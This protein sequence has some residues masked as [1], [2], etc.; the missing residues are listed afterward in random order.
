MH[1][2]D[3]KAPGLW[4]VL[5]LPVLAQLFVECLFYGAGAVPP[6]AQSLG[7]AVCTMVIAYLMWPMLWRNA[8]LHPRNL[9][10][11]SLV[12]AAIAALLMMAGTPVGTWLSLALP[13]AAGVLIVCVLLGALTLFLN[14][15]VKLPASIAH[16]VVLSTLLLTGTA[17][18]WL[19][20]LA[21][22]L[23]SQ[24]FTDLV[25]ALSP[26]G[27][28]TSLIDYDA[29]RSAWFYTHTP[30]GGLRY[31][32]PNPVFFTM[33]YCGLAVLML[34]IST[35]FWRHVAVKKDDTRFTSFHPIY[36]EPTP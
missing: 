33:L 18:L 34:S 30:L 24:V 25:I 1:I 10:V 2:N 36:K 23:A 19:S 7:I 22:V 16:R 14:R 29:L 17:P 3:Y 28:L 11:W 35:V 21:G 4:F 13:L 32:Y 26:V 31:D 9:G 20:P 15:L 12:T 8:L 5:A 27:Y 6:A